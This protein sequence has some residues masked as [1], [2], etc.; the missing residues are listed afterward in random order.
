MNCSIL[1]YMYYVSS[2]WAVCIFR[3]GGLHLP[4][5]FLHLPL[6]ESPPPLNMLAEVEGTIVGR[7]SIMCRRASFIFHVAHVAVL[8]FVLLRQERKHLSDKNRRENTRILHG[9]LLILAVVCIVALP[10]CRFSKIYRN[11]SRLQDI[12]FPRF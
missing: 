2:H 1:Y 6:R 8:V 9:V 12:D 5:V 10:R 4:L 7:F 3:S 11:Y